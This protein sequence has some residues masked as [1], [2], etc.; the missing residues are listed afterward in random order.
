MGILLDA[1]F[2]RVILGIVHPGAAIVVGPVLIAAPYGITRALAN[3][4]ARA[5]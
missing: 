5:W 4:L 2:Q 3:R 1:V